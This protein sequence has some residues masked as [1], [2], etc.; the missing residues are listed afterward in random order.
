LKNSTLI[1]DEETSSE[2]HS[3]GSGRAEI[4]RL[5]E[6]SLFLEKRARIILEAMATSPNPN[7]R[8]DTERR[9]KGL[10]NKKWSELE[11][12]FTL[13]WEGFKMKRLIFFSGGRT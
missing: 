8:G 9:K 13:S 7:E 5:T 2:E 3:H 6:K 12:G 10:L 4:R 11:E 1:G